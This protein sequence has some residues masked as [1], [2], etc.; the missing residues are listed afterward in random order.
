VSFGLRDRARA[1]CPPGSGRRSHSVCVE[2]CSYCATNRPGIHRLGHRPFQAALSVNVVS[3]PSGPLVRERVSPA[4]SLSIYHTKPWALA[5]LLT[6]RRSR[7]RSPGDRRRQSALDCSLNSLVPPPGEKQRCLPYEPLISGLNNRRTPKYKLSTHDETLTRVRQSVFWFS[8]RGWSA[9]PLGAAAALSRTSRGARR[10][11]RLV[12]IVS[13]FRSPMPPNRR[14][15]PAPRRASQSAGGITRPPISQGGAVRALPA[16]CGVSAPRAAAHAATGGL[17]G[18]A[19]WAPG[20]R[21][22][23]PWEQS[24]VDQVGAGAT[25]PNIKN[26]RQPGTPRRINYRAQDRVIDH[27]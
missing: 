9:W 25:R 23:S 22:L 18:R 20:L 14:A 4:I 7:C 13:S 16:L 21:H 24:L 5:G 10:F 11:A 3:R 17:C 15:A 27:P 19:G 1:P 2:A 12:H 6:I 26:P 8:A